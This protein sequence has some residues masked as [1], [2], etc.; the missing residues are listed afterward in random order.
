MDCL[1]SQLAR[2]AAAGPDRTALVD[3]AR[4]VAYG[5]LWR[6]AQAFAAT[7]QRAGISHGDRVAV[8]LPNCPE[9]AAAVYGAWLAGAIVVPLNFQARCRDLRPWL[10]HC[11]ARFVVHQRGHLP[12]EQA[13]AT[14]AFAPAALAVSAGQSLATAAGASYQPHPVRP[15]P[16]DAAMIL[17]TSGTTGAPKGVALTHANLAANCAAVVAYLQLGSDDRVVTVLPFYYA[18]GASVLHTHL[19]RGGCVVLEPN[20]LFPR[21][22]VDTLQREAATGFSGVASA[23]AL[24]LEH[25]AFQGRD[26]ACLRY[27]TQAG[28]PMPSALRSRLQA[29]LP[30]PGLYLMYGQTEATSR[31]T[32]LPP[33]RLADKPGSVG[34]PV[35]GVRLRVVDEEGRDVALGSPGE[36]IARGP[37]IMHGYWNDPVATAAAVRDGWLHTGDIGHLDR[38]GFLYLAGRRSDMIK[39]GAHRIHPLDIEEAIMEIPEV[40]EVAVYGI[41][42]PVMGQVVGARIVASAPIARGAAG[43]RAHCLARLAPYKVP[44]HVEFVGSLPKTASGKVR[45]A[46]L[47]TGTMP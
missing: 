2:A 3:G 23:Y 25:D 14:A 32:W 20:L 24:L 40:R 15:A 4:R 39:A 6:D 5:M 16:S 34:I 27:V 42:D 46:E 17:Y 18:Y 19:S 22:V 45:R 7:L 33:D 30:G 13:L 35:Q 26:L 41:D 12:I 47:A 36:V 38:D 31:L 11:G 43:V 29:A 10:E 9:A 8:V 44:R 1:T 37:N 28:G 21:Q